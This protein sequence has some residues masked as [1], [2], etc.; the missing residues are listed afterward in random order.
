MLEELEACS[1]FFHYQS[2]AIMNSTFSFSYQ[3]SSSFYWD[4]LFQEFSLSP[5]TRKVSL[6]NSIFHESKS[7]SRIQT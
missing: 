1:I 2:F 3:N 5:I 4:M 7:D 6:S